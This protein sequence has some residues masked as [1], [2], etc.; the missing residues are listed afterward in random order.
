MAGTVVATYSDTRS[1]QKVTLAWVSHT[2]GT[3]SGTKTRKLSGIIERVVFVPGTAGV[4]PTDLYDL[5]LLDEQGADVLS[6][7]GA[8]LSNVNKF[9]VAPGVPL[10]DGTTV[11]VKPTAVDDELEL[12]I[13]AAG[14][15]KEG[16]VYLYINRNYLDRQPG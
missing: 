15:A 7:Q 3:V 9:A 13:A 10:K 11:S 12:Q 1:I 4:Q 6:G 5:T 2:D 14:S 16:A 8:N